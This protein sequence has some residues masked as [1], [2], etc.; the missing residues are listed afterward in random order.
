M[1]YYMLQEQ[2]VF[3]VVCV[4]STYQEVTISFC[5][6]SHRC[7]HASHFIKIRLA[8]FVPDFIAAFLLRGLPSLINCICTSLVN[9]IC[10]FVRAAICTA[11]SDGNHCRPRGTIMLLLVCSSHLF[12][13]TLMC[14]SE[15]V[16]RR[17]CSAAAI[18]AMGTGAVSG[19]G[20]AT[21]S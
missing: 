17:C 21:T 8:F 18:Y 7:M 14:R 16:V 4:H 19:N 10:T 9:C 15:I 13:L 5:L 1:Q 6:Y 2:Y 12:A 11:P 3:L 20:T